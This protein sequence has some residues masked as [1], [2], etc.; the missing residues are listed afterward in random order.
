VTSTVVDA[1]GGSR[2]IL[3]RA[4]RDADVVEPLRR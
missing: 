4:Q 1:L 3:G 2:L